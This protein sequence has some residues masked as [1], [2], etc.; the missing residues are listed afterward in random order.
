MT[1]AAEILTEV[2]RRA[3]A[4]DWAGVAE[5]CH[6]DLVIHEPESLPFGGEWKGQDA[7]QRLA[8]VVFGTWAQ[9][10]SE[11]H[12]ITGGREWAVVVLSFAMTSKRTGEALVQSVCEAGR[13]E[14]GRLKEL[15]IHY[16]DA[17]A[18]AAHV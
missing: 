3:G 13:V 14:N 18:V 12:E 8:A 5:L 7:L 2:Y 1:G 15:R 6:P 10:R 17:A 11:I 16:F 9:A 4:G